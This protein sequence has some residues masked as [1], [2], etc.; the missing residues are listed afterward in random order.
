MTQGSSTSLVG[1][2]TLFL[3]TRLSLILSS[4]HAPERSPN[5]HFCL[6][7]AAGNLAEYLGVIAGCFARGGAGRGFLLVYVRGLMSGVQR[8]NVEVMALDQKEVPRTLQRLLDSIAWDHAML[9]DQ[10]Q[11]V[12][13]PVNTHPEAIGRFDETGTT[14][15][16]A[17][18]AGMR[19]TAR[20]TPPDAIPAPQNPTEKTPPRTHKTR[21][22]S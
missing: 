5:A 1:N 6:P 20:P 10:C 22:R 15:S 18:T 21:H 7:S 19:P 11:H 8:K 13:A 9:R 4:E 16:G 14:K 2:V 3:D 17:R 12:V